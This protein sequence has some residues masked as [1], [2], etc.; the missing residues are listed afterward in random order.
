MGWKDD[1]AYTLIRTLH[2]AA[3]MQ[4]WCCWLENVKNI[5]HVHEGRVW[6]AVVSMA[7]GAGYRIKVDVF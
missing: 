4:P 6:K 1:R 2:V 7:R 5:L 3:V